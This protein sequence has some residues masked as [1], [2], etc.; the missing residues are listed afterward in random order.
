MGFACCTQTHP[1]YLFPELVGSLS[2]SLVP[3]NLPEPVFWSS[4]VGSKLWVKNTTVML[5]KSHENDKE[6]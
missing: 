5:V 1:G 6:P 4:L 2:L 3:T